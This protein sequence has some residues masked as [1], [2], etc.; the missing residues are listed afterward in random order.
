MTNK[1]M[2][3]FSLSEHH[4]NKLFAD[5]KNFGFPSATAYFVELIEK[6]F[7]LP[8]SLNLRLQLLEKK[9]DTLSANSMTHHDKSF[10][11]LKD[12]LKRIYVNYKIVFY[13]LSRTFLINP[14]QI[15]Q[16]EV[17]SVNEFVEMEVHKAEKKFGGL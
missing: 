15:S 10:D 17:D 13:I 9:I 2:T 7:T 11:L 5:A 8:D 12:M 14:G 6:G 16:D 3:S 4:K 1:K